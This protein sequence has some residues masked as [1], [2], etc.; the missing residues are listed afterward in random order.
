MAEADDFLCILV[1][2]RARMR[3]NDIAGTGETGK[4][5]QVMIGRMILGHVLAGAAVVLCLQ[6]ALAQQQPAATLRAGVVQLSKAPVP[7][8]ANLSGQASATQ[9]AAIRPLVDGVVREIA[10]QPGHPVKEGDLLFS[11]DPKSYDAALALA[12]AS[13]QNA[14]AALPGAQSALDRAER[15]VGTSVTQEALESARVTFAQAQAAIAEAEASVQTAEINLERTR[16][17]SPFD[18]IAAIASV[19]IGDL[20][21]SGQSDALTT[22]TSL[23]PIYVDLSE[24]SARML[25]LRA[26]VTSGAI[27]P[28]DRIAAQL[29]LENGEAFKGEGQLDSVGASVSTTTGTVNVRFRFANPD[30]LILPGMFVRAELTLGTAEAFLVP[31]LAATLQADGTLRLFVL[32]ENDTAQE[33]RVTSIGSTERAWIVAD[34]IADGTRLLVDN[35]ENMKAGQKIDPVAATISDTGIVSDSAGEN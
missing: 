26:R 3:Q 29:R 7:V 17:T 24:A 35:L 33:L 14:Q 28:G 4:A 13:L 23:D 9:S 20:V 2:D 30:R 19:S 32:D 12:R 21:T 22:V 8:T 27:K 6:P 34:G 5:G 31:Q 11:I 15:L 1:P 10:Y 18:G 25:Q 16:I